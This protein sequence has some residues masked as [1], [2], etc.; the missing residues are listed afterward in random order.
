MRPSSFIILLN[1]IQ[2]YMRFSAILI[3]CLRANKT[4]DGS[5]MYRCDTDLQNSSF[6]GRR[7]I[8]RCCSFSCH[9]IISFHKSVRCHMFRTT[10]LFCCF[11]RFKETKQQTRTFG[12][13][14]FCV[15]CIHNVWYIYVSAH[16]WVSFGMLAFPH[17][18][19]RFA[20][21]YVS[22]ANKRERTMQ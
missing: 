17:F 5:R 7:W 4:E 18:F 12:D 2:I 6:I 19:E 15:F 21:T 22:S 14:L 16:V 10:F 9:K 1:R 3:F 13:D 8:I 11:R 20:K